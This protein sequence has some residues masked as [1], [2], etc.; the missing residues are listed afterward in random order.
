[1]RSHRFGWETRA[2]EAVDSRVACLEKIALG[3]AVA[4]PKGSV[5]V[6]V[7]VVA[8]PKDSAGSRNLVAAAAAVAS[9]A[10]H[11]PAVLVLRMG[12]RNSK[13]I[14][15]ALAGPHKT[16]VGFEVGRAVAAAAELA[17]VRPR[18]RKGS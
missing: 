4:D 10:E 1:M 6:V 3:S 15:A 18:Y 11:N 17:L 8:A 13:D 16:S 7:V 2:V 14:V 9:V 12:C 5:V